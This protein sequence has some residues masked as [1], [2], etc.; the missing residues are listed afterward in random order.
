MA[1]MIEID[2]KVKKDLAALDKAIVKRITT[3]LR[4][5]IAQLDDPRSIGEALKG[6]KLGAFWKYRV[7]DYRIIASIED[8]ALRILV[9]RIGNRK[10]VYRQ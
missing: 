5:R 6:S 7:G 4:E 8:S 1:W 10:E 9:I 2:D 3:F